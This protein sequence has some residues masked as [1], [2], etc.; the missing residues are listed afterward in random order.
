MKFSLVSCFLF[1]VASNASTIVV[2]SGDSIQDAVQKANPGDIVKISDGTYYQD[3]TTVRDGKKD[4]RITITGSR[5]AIVKGSGK[6]GRLFQIH[7]DYITVNGFTIDGKHNDGKKE[8]DYIDKLI[9]AHGNRKTRVILQYGKEFRSSIDGLVISNMK[10]INAGGECSRMRY[11]VT[12]AE[13]YGNHV[14]NCGVHD[15]VFGGMKSV[16][17]ETLYVGT[18]SNQ[19]NDGKNPTPED[20]S[21]Y[22]HIHHNTFVSLANEVD[23]KEGTQYVL[24]EY[25]S[26]STQKDPNSACLDSRTDNVIFRYNDVFGNDGA[27]VRI[28]G[29]TIKN[30]TWGQKNEV[31]GNTFRDNKNG[32]LVVQ[33]GPHG[34]LCE[35]K[36]KN[37]CEVK[38]SYSKDYKDIEGKCSG[39]MDTYWVDNTEIPVVIVEEDEKEVEGVKFEVVNKPVVTSG[40]CYPV[41]IESVDASSEQGGNTAASAIDGR[42]L[43]RWSANG[44]GEWIEVKFSLDVEVD[45]IEVSFYK[46]DERYQEFSLYVDGNE[47][48]DN[49][50]SSGKTTSL[51]RFPFKPITGSSLSFLGHGNSENKWNSL[52][53]LV[54]CG[55]HETEQQAVD[56]SGDTCDTLSKLD[57]KSIEI[58]GSDGND[59]DNL[60]DGDLKTKWSSEHKDV[61]LT[62][63]DTS[64]VSD[65]G[66]AFYNGDKND[67]MFDVLALTKNGWSEVVV[68]GHSSK[69]KGIESYDI[70][71]AGV[72]EIKLVF[73]GSVNDSGDHDESNS[74]SEIELY[75]C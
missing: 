30:K 32:A 29:H 40:K 59:A 25:N 5:K 3:V 34:P 31:Y 51:Q 23:V 63:K 45:A 71:L 74:V 50:I 2:K 27:A 66:I 56:V 22:I 38:G 26:C 75:G 16:N 4:A 19:W 72:D 12:N 47:V 46:G 65:I 69:S 64:Y 43:T 62:L 7:H 18:S 37:S 39:V 6:E 58:S 57:V 48:V 17:G 44:D 20:E 73:Y 41:Q 8:T 68:D 67:N 70:D 28:G 54:V 11:F 10:L 21:R 55:T 1:V 33:T 49:K 53:E 61:I 42:S 60:L 9:Y 52:T 36:C 15:F 35:N 14:E 24:V 13:Y